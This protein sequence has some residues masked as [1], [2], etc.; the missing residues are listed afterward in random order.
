M[1]KFLFIIIAYFL[2]SIP[3]SYIL[4]KY[5]KHEDIRKYGSGNIGT[6]NAFRVFGKI[7]GILVLF[8]DVF[9][10]WEPSSTCRKNL[11]LKHS[12]PLNSER[13]LLAFADATIC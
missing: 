3:F 2:G 4:G 12:R 9:K 10:G 5:I 6:T 11:R 1:Y 7:I 8:L 13:L